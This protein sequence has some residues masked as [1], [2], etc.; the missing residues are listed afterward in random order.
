MRKSVF[1]ALVGFLALLGLMTV[2]A[3]AGGDCCDCYSSCGYHRYSTYGYGER[4]YVFRPTLAYYR[5]YD[6]RWQYA[7]AYYNPPRFSVRV[8]RRPVLVIERR[9]SWYRGW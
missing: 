8:S 1:T 9:R 2:P 6:P 4:A 3:A 5:R 7:A